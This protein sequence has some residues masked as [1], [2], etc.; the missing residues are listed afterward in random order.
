MPESQHLGQYSN[1]F[2]HPHWLKSTFIVGANREFYIQAV[3]NQH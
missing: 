1:L 2:F 3:C